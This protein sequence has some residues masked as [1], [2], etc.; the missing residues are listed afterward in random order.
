MKACEV[1]CISIRTYHRWKNNSDGDNRKGAAKKVPRKLIQEEEQLII[2]TSCNDRFRD[3]YP[4][5]I[6]QP[7][8]DE[9]QYIASTSI[10]YRVLRSRD[11]LHHR[12]KGRSSKKRNPPPEL[13]ATGP[14]QVSLG[15]YM[16][17]NRC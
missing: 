10:Y 4:Y 15:Y 16:A 3:C 7:L 12:K 2:D 17:E 1:L 11:L 14:D 9:G 13:V 6:V 5:Q 8:L